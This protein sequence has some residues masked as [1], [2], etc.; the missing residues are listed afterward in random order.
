LFHAGDSLKSIGWIIVAGSV[1]SSS[2][3]QL[4]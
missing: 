1:P 4:C 3:L 2:L